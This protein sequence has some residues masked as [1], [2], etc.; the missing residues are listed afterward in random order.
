M[1]KTE[2]AAFILNQCSGSHFLQVTPPLRFQDQGPFLFALTQIEAEYYFIGFEIVDS[3]TFLATPQILS[4]AFDDP[5]FYDLVTD[6]MDLTSL[7]DTNAQHS[8]VLHKVAPDEP[9][10]RLAVHRLWQTHAEIAAR[11]LLISPDGNWHKGAEFRD[12][13]VL[14]A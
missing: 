6:Q 7:D 12:I 9:S 13:P 4:T 8:L 3:S 11:I 2:I 1:T 10:C 14:F 5:N